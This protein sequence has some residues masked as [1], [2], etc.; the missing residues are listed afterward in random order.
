MKILA[1]KTSALLRRF[2]ESLLL[3]G[4]RL[5]PAALFWQSGQTK[6]EGWAL[7]DSALYLFQEE[8]QLPF[9]DPNLAAHLAAISEHLFPLLL[10]LGLA[11]RF[12]ALALLGM[13]LIIQ[14]LVYP[15]AW[16][17]HGTW[18]M[19]FLWLV[20]R[21]PGWFSLDHLFVRAMAPIGSKVSPKRE[22]SGS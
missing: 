5:F 3:L 9:L 4:S 17:T 15:D 16:P 7:N 22:S 11:T 20:I 6:V 19:L 2:P 8:Y 1:L 10:V 21:G 13:T 18:A 12:S 14:C